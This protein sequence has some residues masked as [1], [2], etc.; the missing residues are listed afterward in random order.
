QLLVD[1]HRLQPGPEGGDRA[2]PGVVDERH[3]GAGRLGALRCPDVNAELAQARERPAAVLVI[4]HGRD[5]HA[6]AGEPRQLHSRDRTS[7]RRLLEWLARM[8]DVTRAGDVAHARE[9]HPLDVA[10]DRHLR[11]APVHGASLTQS[12]TGRPWRW[13][14]GR[15]PR[16]YGVVPVLVC[17]VVVVT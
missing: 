1:A 13:G 3:R 15:K 7:S 6:I 17:V 2:L 10:D 5:E 4:A 14:A 12:S 8:D 11:L 9:P 16:C